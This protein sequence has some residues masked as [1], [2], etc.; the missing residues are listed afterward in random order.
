MVARL[1]RDCG[2]YLGPEEELGFDVRN[3]E[4]H[5]E[6]VRFVEL[7]DEILNRLGGSWHNPPK[8]R[9]GW[10]HTPELASLM[11]PAKKLVERLGFV[12]PGDGKI[13]EIQ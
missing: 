6:N 3:G 12:S 8:F 2:L 1:L 13:R 11:A 7:N 9:A 5:W 4:P 10:E